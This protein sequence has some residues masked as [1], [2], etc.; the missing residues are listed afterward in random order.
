M[1]EA[2]EQ[3]TTALILD[4]ALHL[5][6]RFLQAY[7]KGASHD[8]VADASPRFPSDGG[9]R[10]TVSLVCEAVNRQFTRTRAGPAK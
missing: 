4:A 1:A 3:G 5:F 2:A 10:S 7:A 6:H 9:D 8:R